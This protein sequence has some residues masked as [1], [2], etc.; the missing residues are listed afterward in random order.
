MSSLRLIINCIREENLF[1][2]SSWVKLTYLNVIMY[3]RV[4]W[5]SIGCRV[6]GNPG[7][8]LLNPSLSFAELL[9]IYKHL[10]STTLVVT[11]YLS[12]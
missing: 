12:A 5:S 7:C 1:D 8:T 11:L 9:D 3:V 4:Y 2:S 10:R 6:E